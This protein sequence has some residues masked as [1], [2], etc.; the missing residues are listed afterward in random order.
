MPG[1]LILS[2]DGSRAGYSALLKLWQLSSEQVG[3]TL[4]T[5]MEVLVL[6]NCAVIVNFVMQFSSNPM[7]TKSEVSIV[8]NLYKCS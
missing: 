7:E 3:L 8:V 4:S 5:S 1:T 2:G 6:G